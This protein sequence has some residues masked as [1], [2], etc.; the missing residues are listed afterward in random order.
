MSDHRSK[1][2]G[3]TTDFCFSNEAI[4]A[5]GLVEL[6]FMVDSSLGRIS[7]CYH[8]QNAYIVFF[9]TLSLGP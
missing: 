8:S 7:K 9:F 1:L 2:G 3:D 4:S 6:P 5:L